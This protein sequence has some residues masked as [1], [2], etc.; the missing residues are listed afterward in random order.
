MTRLTRALVGVAAVAV[1]VLAVG[2]AP[3]GA[4][5]VDP[6]AVRAGQGETAQSRTLEARVL[7]VRTGDLL[8]ADDG[9][10]AVR[11][12]TDAVWIVVDV[13]LTARLGRLALDQ[14]D[15]EVGS[16]QY[17]VSSIADDAELLV[18]PYGAGVPMRGSLVFEVPATVLEHGSARLVLHTAIDDRLD[19]VPVIAL[20]LRGAPSSG[21]VES[22]APT[23]VSEDER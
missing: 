12:P 14:A 21:E 3:N 10:E 4:S 11:L 17:R 19:S 22:E 20:D 9:T 7:D 23:V 16:V 6:F 8:V 13:E 5:V 15:L 18:M 2:T 1:G